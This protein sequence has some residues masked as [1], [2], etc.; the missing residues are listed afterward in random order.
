MYI[1]S[2]IHLYH[3]HTLP[4]LPDTLLPGAPSPPLALIAIELTSPTLPR[5]SPL[6]FSNPLILT[7][8][9]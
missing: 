6:P 9:Y 7:R 2:F 1:P 3:V 8:M 5:L 4:I